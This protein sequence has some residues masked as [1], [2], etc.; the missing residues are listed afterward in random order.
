MC[1]K[2]DVIHVTYLLTSVKLSIYNIISSVHFYGVCCQQTYHD[3]ILKT[4]SLS[5]LKLFDPQI[6]D[7]NSVVDKRLILKNTLNVN[8]PYDSTKTSFQ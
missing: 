3:C 4:K 2:N 6:L 7:S 8:I 5:I 1:Y